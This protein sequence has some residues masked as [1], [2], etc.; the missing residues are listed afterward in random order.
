MLE[1][2]SNS[3]SIFRSILE[4]F[5][6]SKFYGIYTFDINVLTEIKKK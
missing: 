1:K 2:F 4:V 3:P 5:F 6:L